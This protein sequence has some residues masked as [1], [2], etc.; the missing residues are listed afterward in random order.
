MFHRSSP[1]YY[2]FPLGTWFSIQVRMSIFFPIA[3]LIL[4]YRL[5]SWELG[6]VF[7]GLLFVSVFAH[8]LA[9]VLAA[10]LTG[11]SG[12][13][14]LIWPLGGLAYVRP[15][16][17]FRSQFCTAA[18]GPALNLA[19]CVLALPPVWHS[20]QLSE[21]LNPLVLPQVSL[22]HD[23]ARSLFLMMFSANWLLFLVN[24][25][26][27]YPLDGGRMLRAALSTRAIHEVADELYLRIGFLI[28]LAIMLLGLCFG[29]EADAAIVFIGAVI[30]AL[31]LYETMQLQEGH[32]Q[33]ERLLGTYD[34]SHGYTSLEE[35]SHASTPPRPGLFQRWL[36]RRR[37]TKELQLR[38]QEAEEDHQADAILQKVH[39]YGM[40][41]LTD[42]ERKLLAR[43][44][45][46]YRS[47]TDRA[48]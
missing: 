47:R 33:E 29:G 5:E 14:I 42:A 20:G 48:T 17:T 11:G 34:F 27:A 19:I 6:L 32:L 15:A 35:S 43:A 3:L 18:A 30:L 41:S 1:F 46:R 13:E 38:Q 44:S 12:D 21:A 45:A 4:C 7:G 8:E 36:Q 24:L 23:L 28:A 9:H 25:I 16:A 10:H 2:S 40:D 39:Q 22:E 31:N 37:E 26:P